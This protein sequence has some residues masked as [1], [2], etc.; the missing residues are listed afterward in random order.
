[1][2]YPELAGRADRIIKMADGPHPPHVEEDDAHLPLHPADVAAEQIAEAL[3]DLD[4]EPHDFLH[5]PWMSL[6]GLV[7]GIPSGD[8]WFV[9]AFSGHGKT[10][11][12]MSALNQWFEAGRRIYYMGLESK[13]KTLRTH[14]ACKRLGFDAGDVLSGKAAKDWPDWRDI[15]KRIGDDIRAQNQG[16]AGER[17]YIS[18]V[19]EVNVRQL[20]E[21]CEQAADLGSDVMIIDHID[22]IEPE[23]RGRSA[24]EE[25]RQ[26]VKA[27][28]GYAQK[29]DLRL[30]VATQLNNDALKGNRIG[31]YQAPQP[32]HVY[33]GSHKRQ[34]ASGMIGLYR[35]LKFGSVDVEALKRFRAGDGEPQDVC[36]PNTMAAVIM[37]HRLYGNR[38]G[39]RAF[40]GV[41]HGRVV[42]LS[43]ADLA[44]A[45]T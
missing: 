11:F 2:K 19:P 17:V 37:K 40:L 25:S 6:D 15:R 34:I 13:P 7:G 39:K 36:E 9:G 33:M 38:E 43:E 21:G 31:L 44:F 16:H 29:F 18:P 42:Q 1:M 20:R 14:W 26:V 22:H 10:T 30:I 45:T 4:R 41:D 32:H 3:A 5:F 8:V 28:M 12:L 27:L 24:F 35:P 23:G